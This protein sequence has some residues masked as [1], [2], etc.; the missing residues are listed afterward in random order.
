M[1]ARRTRICS[2]L[3]VCLVSGLMASGGVTRAGEGA[4]PRRDA[5]LLRES[6]AASRRAL[7][8]LRDRQRE[9]GSWSDHPAVTALVVTA[10]V[11]S[12]QEGFGPRSEAVTRALH[13]VRRF[14]QP[15]GGIYDRFYP[16]YCTSVCVSALAA[17][18]LPEDQ[19]LLANGRRFLIHLQ[20]DESEGFTPDDAQYGGWGY[21]QSPAREEMHRADLSNTQFAL[22]ALRRLEELEKRPDADMDVP[23]WVQTPT[24][25]AYERA[26]KFL[27]RCQNLKATN[28]QPWASDDGGFVYH[29]GQSKAGAG[30]EGGLRS[31]G[32]MTYAGLMSMVYARLDRDD[33]RVRAAYEWACRHWSVTENPGLGQQGLYYYY[34]TMARALNAYGGEALVD[35][36]G[37]SHDWRREL[38][39]QL[40]KVQKADGSWVNENGR[41]MEQM[42]DLVTAYALLAIQNATQRW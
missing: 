16:S 12:G 33:V 23:G 38:V 29:P 3:T 31:Y 41:W 39:A 9:N 18:G 11:G 8:C 26:I 40:L 27:E 28:D 7:A 17:A 36:G 2:L 34:L 10:M 5:S 35:A 22:D 42:P 25:L 30:P 24:E 4:A 14:V 1:T 13:Y 37:V 21:E 20:A 19:E 6:Q 15:D 32:G